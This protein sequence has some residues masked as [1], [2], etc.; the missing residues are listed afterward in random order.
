VDV[1]TL[2]VIGPGAS[3]PTKIYLYRNGWEGRAGASGSSWTA[4][5]WFE[6]GAFRGGGFSPMC[7]ALSS[8]NGIREGPGDSLRG[9]EFDCAHADGQLALGAGIV[10]PHPGGP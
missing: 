4:D 7:A 8:D 5:F 6:L 3:L 10:G 1:G 9:E 2:D